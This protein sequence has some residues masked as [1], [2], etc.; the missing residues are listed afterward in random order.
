MSGRRWQLS[1]LH[2]VVDQPQQRRGVRVVKHMPCVRDHGEATVGDLFAQPSRLALYIDDLVFRTADDLNGHAQLCMSA[3]KP[4]RRIRHRPRV[5]REC[6]YLARSQRQRHRELFCKTS[7]YPFRREHVLDHG[8][9]RCAAYDRRNRV[10]QDA[11]Y[12]RI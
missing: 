5:F 3:R 9:R 4:G 12:N 1:C 6:S 10:A 7:G 8:S 11:P 2:G